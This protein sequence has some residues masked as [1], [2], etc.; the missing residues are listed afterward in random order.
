MC[1]YQNFRY[2][3]IINNIKSCADTYLGI[4]NMKVKLLAVA[5]VMILANGNTMAQS[6]DDSEFTKGSSAGSLEGYYHFSK[7]TDIFGFFGRYGKY[8]ADNFYWTVGLGYSKYHNSTP[9]QKAH[10]LSNGNVSYWTSHMYTDVNYLHVPV[11]I[12][13]AIGKLRGFTVRLEGGLMVNY[14]MSMKV[15]ESGHQE[16]VTDYDS[17][18]VVPTVR[19]SIG[20]WSFHLYAQYNIAKN[21]MFMYGFAFQW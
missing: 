2:A 15:G 1:I 21:G 8:L 6:S 4:T 11:N 20:V 9:Y 10:V 13:Y 19:A 18:G 16:K 7:E 5:L 17:F 14:I 3:L 12:G